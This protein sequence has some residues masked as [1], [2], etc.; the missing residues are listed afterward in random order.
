MEF[1]PLHAERCPARDIFRLLQAEC[2][3]LVEEWCG[4]HPCGTEAFLGAGRESG[5]H[6]DGFCTQAAGLANDIRPD[7]G[8]HKNERPW[9]N[10]PHRA[11]S[12][13]EEIEGIVDR[14]QPCGFARGGELETGGGGGGENECQRG[15]GV[16]QGLDELEGDIHFPDAYGV[17]PHATGV[18]DLFT[19]AGRVDA[20]PLGEFVAV[21]SPAN[22]SHKEAWKHQQDCNGKNDVVEE[23]DR[24]NHFLAR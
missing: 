23:A 12:D 2:V 16:A 5:I 17:D 15:I 18:G 6:Q 19:N 8:F 11:A 22:H 21:F 7:F 10:E 13:R 20:K 14:L 4:D 24:T 3:E 9:F 1:F